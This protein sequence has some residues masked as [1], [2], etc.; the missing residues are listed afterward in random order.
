MQ[1]RELFEEQDG[2]PT[3]FS[4]VQKQTV[5]L[6]SEGPDGGTASPVFS[7]SPQD[8]VRSSSSDSCNSG[9]IYNRHT[10]ITLVYTSGVQK[11]I[12]VDL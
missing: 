2:Y 7:E 12:I 8:L 3:K 9:K 5:H 10:S 1:E 11:C 6:E 4:Q